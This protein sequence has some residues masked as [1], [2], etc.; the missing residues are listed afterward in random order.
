M[1]RVSSDSRWA[2]TER[3]ASLN[4]FK[5]GV[6]NY[7]HRF[8]ASLMVWVRDNTCSR[9]AS[10][11]RTVVATNDST[12]ATR[13]LAHSDYPTQALRWLS[14]AGNRLG[15]QGAFSLGEA[16]GV[17]CSLTHLDVSFN[18][19]S[20]SGAAALGHGLRGNTAIK[21]LQVC[22]RGGEKRVYRAT[23]LSRAWRRKLLQM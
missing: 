6:A 20:C 3:S 18:G 4:L 12:H 10:F 15:D 13:W 7:F 1:V 11:W 19:I 2:P 16:L 14:L 21:N 17:N 9:P 23:D 22:N 8:P 5:R